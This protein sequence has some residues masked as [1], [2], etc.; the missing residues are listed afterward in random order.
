MNRRN[1]MKTLAVG[2]VAS[3]IG[4]HQSL[5]SNLRP[6]RFKYGFISGIIK[7]EMAEDWRYALSR[8][9]S[10]GYRELETGKPPDGVNPSE[11]LEFCNQ[12]GLDIVAGGVK[13]TDDPDH[14]RRELDELV[15]L[16]VE[17]A[18]CYWPWN[19]STPFSLENCKW[20]S[21]NL[22]M[23]GSV[24]AEYDLPFCWHNH[25]GEFKEMEEGL[26]FHYL[27]K[28]TDPS[29]V[30]V[31]LDVY[32]AAKGHAD[33]VELLKQYKGRFHILHLKDMAPGPEQDFACVGS[34][35]IDFP[36]IL[37]EAKH[38]EIQHLI[39][40]KDKAVQGLECLNA[41]MHYFKSLNS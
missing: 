39:V 18:V 9:A 30:K 4:L 14:L 34:G 27:M 3:S 22:D 11:F 20:S 16:E 24:C 12:I 26:P 6:F 13:M 41:A 17:A 19:V 29:L 2:S 38:Q 8:A 25:D 32:W 33:P 23:M 1:F 40:E 28:H 31:E 37:E 10:F 36:S 35:I 15:K 7:N 21:A 5:A